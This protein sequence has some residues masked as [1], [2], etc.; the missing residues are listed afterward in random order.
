MKP[1]S[2]VRFNLG[3]VWSTPSQDIMRAFLGHGERQ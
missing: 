3:D 2:V 1:K